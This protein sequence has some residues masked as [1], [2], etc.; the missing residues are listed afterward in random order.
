MRPNLTP[1]NARM[2]NLELLSKR[3]SGG[4]RRRYGYRRISAEL[5]AMG[6]TCAPEDGRLTIQSREHR[7]QR[8]G[9]IPAFRMMLKGWLDM[10]S[11]QRCGPPVPNLPKTRFRLLN[12]TQ[13][14]TADNDR[15]VWML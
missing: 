11:A 13:K 4:H 1:A 3:F 8:P 5:T 12:F 2:W 9:R 6:L 10:S 15:I 14:N 7:I